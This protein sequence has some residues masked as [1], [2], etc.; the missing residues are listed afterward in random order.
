MEKYRVNIYGI[1]KLREE[2]EKRY[3]DEITRREKLNLCFLCGTDHSNLTKRNVNLTC[4]FCKKTNTWDIEPHCPGGVSHG[5]VHK[6]EHCNSSIF[7]IIYYDGE[8]VVG[9][10]NSRRK[11]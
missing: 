8:I 7:L 9:K 10:A 4:P 11:K 6:C 3:K 2:A 1:D 5:E